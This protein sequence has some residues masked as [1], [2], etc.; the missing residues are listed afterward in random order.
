MLFPLDT[1]HTQIVQ[2]LNPDVKYFPFCENVELNTY[3]VLWEFLWISQR[4]NLDSPLS[5]SDAKHYEFGE[6]TK[7]NT[8]KSPKRVFVSS[9]FDTLHIPPKSADFRVTENYYS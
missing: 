3:E 9:P 1:L 2:S 8:G 5:R 4:I 7:L 6:N